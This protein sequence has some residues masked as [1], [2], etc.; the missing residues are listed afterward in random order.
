MTIRQSKPQSSGSRVK[1][2]IKAIGI[3]LN[4][5]LKGSQASESKSQE[6]VGGLSASLR[7][8]RGFS[9]D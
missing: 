8:R 7:V 5:S 2:S 3:P 6:R 4:G 1:S 9:F